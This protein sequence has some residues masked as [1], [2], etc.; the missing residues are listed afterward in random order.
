VAP[1]LAP[2]LALWEGLIRLALAA[3]L[4]GAIGIEREL[5]EQEAGL[6]THMLVCVGA[7]AFMIVGVYGWSDFQLSNGIGVVVDPSRVASYV[8]SGIGFLGA[9]AIIRHGINVRGLTTAASLWVVAAIGVA[10]GVGMY[11][12]A[13]GVTALVILALWPLGAVKRVLA[14]RRA[15]AKRLAVTLDPQAS[16]VETL[17]AVEEGGFDIE[18]VEVAE[19]DEARRLDVIVR[20]PADTR[21]GPL[22]DRV[23]NLQGVRSAV[24]AE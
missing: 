23:A 13:I 20:A 22:L 10:V 9:G 18:S 21:F 15:S 11:G 6:R 2:E 4:A 12:L 24:A 16:I 19:E 3:V 5:R 14:G 17:A 1:R 8:V 7:A